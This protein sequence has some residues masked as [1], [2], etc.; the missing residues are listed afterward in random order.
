[1]KI[2]QEVNEKN[3]TVERVAMA[4]NAQ[5]DQQLRLS[6]TDADEGV[7]RPGALPKVTG[8]SSTANKALMSE[9]GQAGVEN[10]GC[11]GCKMR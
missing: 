9:F 7:L 11:R 4:A 5:V 10:V 6:L 3:S 8:I 1:M 2:G